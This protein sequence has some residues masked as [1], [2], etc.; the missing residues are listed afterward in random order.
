MKPQ[1]FQ[2]VPSG[3]Q[4]R[5][6]GFSLVELLVVLVI[7]GVL[8][9]VAL[10]AYT[11]Y[12]QRG[13]RTEAMA[14]LLES[15]HFMERYYSANGQYL[16][17]AN[18]VPLLPQRLQGIPSQGT[19]RY[20]LSVREAT[21]NSYVLQAVPEGS[22]AGDVCGSLTINQAGLRGVLNSTRSVAECWR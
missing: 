14:A 21:L 1:V 19:V 18:A 15:Q 4:F 6:A 9:A 16:S 17:P 20:Q 11:R 7:M 5:L 3:R 13:H 10:P 2:S 22:M 8:S 12:V